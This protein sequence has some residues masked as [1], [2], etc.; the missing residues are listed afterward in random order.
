MAPVA[1][2]CDTE[3]RVHQW[4]F[5]DGKVKT[6][7]TAEATH[8]MQA[9]NVTERI[10]VSLNTERFTILIEVWRLEA[11]FDRHFVPWSSAFPTEP[12]LGEMIEVAEALARVEWFK[13]FPEGS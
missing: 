5:A 1:K 8:P 10:A 13:L 6:Q 9:A 11:G 7:I 2:N 4:R 12:T 3:V